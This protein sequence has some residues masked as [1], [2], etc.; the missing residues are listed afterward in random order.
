MTTFVVLGDQPVAGKLLTATMNDYLETHFEVTPNDDFYVVVALRK[1]TTHALTA[2][3]DW[4]EKAEVSYEVFAQ[5]GDTDRRSEAHSW[6]VCDDPMI[7]AVEAGISYSNSDTIVLA[8]VG[9]SEQ[10]D[11]VA[12]AIALALESNVSVRDLTE[13]ALTYINFCGDTVDQPPTKEDIMSE[14]ETE[15]VTLEDLVALAAEG[16]EDAVEAL[17]EAAREYG[18]DP[19][20]YDSWEEVGALLQTALEDEEGEEPEPEPDPEEEEEEEVEPED[21][22]TEASLKGKTLKEVREIANA[23]GIDSKLPRPKLHKALIEGTGVVEEEEVEEEAPKATP[24]KTAA[25]KSVAEPKE[26]AAGAID[27]DALADLII[28]KLIKRIIAE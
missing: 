6:V 23:A 19:D 11:D 24:K 28:E 10:A 21:G 9:E 12:G 25:K 2:V 26:A 18:I 14:E 13:G 22:W 1:K 15:E 4:C 16:D 27:L 5:S 7:D 20:E 3:M 8:L 17:D